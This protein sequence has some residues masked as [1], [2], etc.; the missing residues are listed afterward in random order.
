MEGDLD[1]H[2]YWDGRTGCEGCVGWDPAS[3]G[4]EWF[5]LGIF[6]TE[7]GPYVHWARRIPQQVKS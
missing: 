4:P 5:L 2:P 3:P 1:D 6:D 7:N